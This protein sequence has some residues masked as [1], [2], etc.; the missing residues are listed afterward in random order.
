MTVETFCVCRRETERVKMR[1]IFVGSFSSLTLNASLL[2]RAVRMRD[3]PH[4][5]QERFFI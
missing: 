4:G 3:P 5:L 2:R 1:G